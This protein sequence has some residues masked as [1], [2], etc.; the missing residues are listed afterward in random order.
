MTVHLK[1]TFEE[2]YTVTIIEHGLPLTSG[3]YYWNAEIS[4][5]WIDYSFI[6]SSSNVF[7]F[8]VPNGTYTINYYYYFEIPLTPGNAY[9]APYSHVTI[10]GHNIT[11]NATYSPGSASGTSDSL[12]TVGIP[13]VAGIV[14]VAVGAGIAALA[15]RRKP[16][17]P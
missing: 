13:V 12:T 9:N 17:L 2:Q 15:F 4:G 7:S 1:A 11:V 6:S 3:N 10:S 8:S 14:G 5:K 16:K